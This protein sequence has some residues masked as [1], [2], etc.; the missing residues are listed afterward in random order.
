MELVSFL[1]SRGVQR[2]AA[3]G[4]MSVVLYYAGV[5]LNSWIPWCVMAIALLMEHLAWGQGVAHGVVLVVEMTDT[6]RQ[7]LQQV[8]KEL[9]HDI[10]N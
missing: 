9:D 8:L 2:I 3:L 5:Q 4:A 10:R 7:K 6:D 1:M